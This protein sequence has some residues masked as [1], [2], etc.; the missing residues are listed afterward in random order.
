MNLASKYPPANRGK[1]VMWSMLGTFPFGGM[2]WHRLHYLVGLRRLGFD[3]WYVEDSDRPIYSSVTFSPTTDYSENVKYLSQQ[4]DSVGMGDRWIFRPPGVKEFCLGATDL[5]GLKKLYKEAD[6]VLN[7]SAAQEYRSDFSIIRCLVYLETDPVAKQVAVANGD[8]QLI[9]KLNNYHYFFTYGENLGN[10][11]CLVPIERYNWQP[12]RPPICVDWWTNIDHQVAGSVLTTIANLKHSGKDVVWKEETW[13]WSKHY[14][15]QQFINL[16]S[17]S[18][19][20]LEIA[21]CGVNDDEVTDIRKHG[22]HTIPSMSLSDPDVYRNYILSSLGEFTIAKEQ[23]VRPRSGWFSDRSACY[24]AAG[25]PVITQDT[26][27][28][29]VLPTGEGLFAFSTEDEAL[30]AIE[31]VSLDYERHSDAAREIAKEYFD[32]DK[33]LGNMLQQIGLM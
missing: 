8:Q 21:L 24:L 11:D 12:T 23:Y 33:V 7:H 19:L 28:G 32:A 2:T 20:P 25:R 5:S 4:M 14:E 29:N 26:G 27:F 31:E 18:K 6:A 10:H 22:W 9:Q 13:H 17:R 3:V 15:F 16:P 1:I 30:A